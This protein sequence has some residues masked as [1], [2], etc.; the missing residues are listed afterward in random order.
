MGSKKKK[1]T[2]GYRYSWDLFCGLGRGPINSIVAITADK[3][4]VWLGK[5]SDANKNRTIYINKP[6]LFGGEDT[7]GEGGIQGNIEIMMGEL[8]QIPSNSLKS[9]LK[10]LI[11][12]FR[13]VVTTFYSGLISCYSASPKP[14]SYRVRRTTKGWD[15]NNVWYPEKCLILLRDD[16][17]EITGIDSEIESRM[18]PLNS[19]GRGHLIDK[20]KSKE[21]IERERE[22]Q[23]RKAEERRRKIAELRAALNK[24]VRDI[25]AMNPAHIL[26]ECATNRDWGRGLNWDE[27]DIESFK[28]A[29][30][31]LFNEKF[32]LCFRYNR[33]DQL[34]TFI[35]QILDHIGAAQYADLSTGKLT[36]K[37]IRNDYDPE[38]LPLFNYD[39]GILSVQDDDSASND[40]TYNEIVVTYSNPVTHEDGTVRAQNLA[41]IQQVGLISNSVEYKAVPTQ[42]LA[43]RVAERDL[44]MNA[45]GITRLIIKF[46]RRGG[47]LEPAS[48]FRVS[49]PDRDIENM[50]LRVGKIEEQNDGALLITGVQDVFSLSSTSYNTSQQTSEWVAPDNSIRA[51]N[52]VQLIELPYAVLVSTLSAADLDYVK[53]SSGY[54]GVM[55]S[56]PTLASIN[57]ILQSRATGAEFVT[58]NQG[59]WTPRATL[60]RNIDKLTSKF[61]IDS[62]YQPSI[63]EGILINDE[64]MRIDS[65]DIKNNTIIV[66]RGC[67]DSLPRAHK[68]GSNIWFYMNNIETD[69]IDYLS[70]EK[71]DVKLLTQTSAGTLNEGIA[72]IKS[73]CMQHRQIRPYLPGNIRINN[74]L[75]PDSIKTAE[76]YVL[77]FAHRDR[78]LQIDR[79]IDCLSSNIGPENNAT[80]QIEISDSYTK[81]VLWQIN[82]TNTLIQLPYSSTDDNINDDIHI[83]TLYTIR[84]G[85]ESLNKFTVKLPK[86]RVM[87]D[88]SEVDNAE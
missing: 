83:L 57:Y 16:L 55:A 26:F 59:D 44:E 39:N 30:D 21:E 32:G 9:I 33:Q 1:V 62:D 36:L 72:P 23:K 88:V 52:D 17:S 85:Y 41:S 79:L 68:A 64:F 78:V 81:A 12:G 48:C 76:N 6:N 3:K 2:V 27:I 77:S 35:Q 38:K 66:G 58:Q 28:K 18:R 29:A 67:L 74:M 63:G 86:G 25:H 11:P 82:T 49:L 15:K 80:Y 61:E 10:G 20:N 53:P 42:E 13:G 5:E 46:D 43:A 84:D 14:W 24:N 37:L 7:G 47:I 22:E 45:A 56:A 50:I 87:T 71:V 54:I 8:N 70:S 4:I 19:R 51:V 75:Y 40:A 34:Q 60:I 65:V 73:V 69:D 31:T